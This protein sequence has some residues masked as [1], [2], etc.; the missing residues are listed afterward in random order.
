M[1]VTAVLMLGIDATVLALAIPALSADLAPSATE[2][3][4]IGDIYSFAV[5]GLLVTMGALADRVGR[6]RVLLVG[7]TGFGLASALAAF[8]PTAETLIAARFLLGV[9]GATLMPS[10]LSLIRNLFPEPRERTRAIAIWSAAASAGVAL[11]PLVGGV[12]IE[13]FWWGAVF[14]I[15]V[16][17]VIALVVAGWLL[18][19]E[20]RD[21]RPGPFDLVSSALSMLA[22]V[23]LVFAVKHV[24]DGGADLLALTTAAVGVLAGWAFIRRQRR[25][26]SPMIDV[27]LFR[28]AA[29]S[30]AVLATLISV[31]AL[32]GLLYFFSQY[33]QLARGFTPIQ[34]GLAE[35]P[36]TLA[37][38]AAI[39]L[40]GLTLRRFGLGRSIATG[41]ALTS[42]G[43]L[44][45]AATEGAESYVWLAMALVPLGLGVGLT[46]T[47]CTDA[48]VGT[49]PAHKA[50]AASAI[51]ETAY[52][53]GVAL[54][55]AV[56]GSLLSV[57][58]RSG[59]ALPAGL[60]AETGDQVRESLA[61]AV[62]VLPPDSE[63]V[64]TAQEAFVHA[65]QTTAV[66]AALLAL[67]GAVIAWRTIPRVAAAPAGHDSTLEPQP[68]GRGA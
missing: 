52:E 1:L 62:T 37:S 42:L 34:A 41:L 9:T 45:V 24:A 68:L 17:V 48:V 40:V 26:P 60:P 32:S 20:S 31:F 57:L 8:A 22:V 4:W 27:A 54:G 36:S 30:G 23:P 2:L 38:L 66:I 51:S 43:L 6:K 56:L 28:N 16:P 35:L 33:L 63:L 50:G 47:L 10:T 44:L 5:A 29:F 25:L 65:M 19:P 21:P 46:L 61:S 15:N 13:H 18:L 49:A 59:L 39:A 64:H 11:G 67:A 14:L 3:L 7:A 55:I 58:Y 12:L 53:L